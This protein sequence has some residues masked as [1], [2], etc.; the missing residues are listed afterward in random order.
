MLHLKW[1]SEILRRDESPKLLNSWL[2]TTLCHIHKPPLSMK[3]NK[4]LERGW[5]MA[6][7]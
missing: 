7:A 4:G 6:C 3:C 1:H 5:R 2:A